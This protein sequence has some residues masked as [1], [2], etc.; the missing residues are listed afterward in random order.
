MPKQSYQK[1]L[2]SEV[3]VRFPAFQQGFNQRWF[4]SNCEAVYL[5][6]TA[7]GA[8]EALDDALAS[9]G[10]G[11]KIKSGG[12][13]Y[14]NFVFSSETKAILDVTAMTESGYDP[15]L[16]YF[17]SSGDTNW[18][19]FKV[20]FR[21]Y[22]KVL[23]AGSCYSVGLGGHISGGGDGILSRM[24][25]LTIDW[26]SGVEVVVKDEANQP[27]KVKYVSSE[28][29]GDDYD[30][31]WAHT[32]GGGGNF[33][34]ITKYYFKELPDSPKGAIISTLSFSWDDLTAIRIGLILDW[35]VT[36]AAQDYNWRTSC[37][38]QMMHKSAGYMKLLI[39][40]AYFTDDEKEQ[41]RLYHYQLE[42]ELESICPHV[43]ATSYSAGHAGVWSIPAGPR[44]K[45]TSM[46]D[47]VSEQTGDYTYYEAVQTMNSSG[48]NQR[49]KYKSAYMAKK[50]PDAQIQQIFKHLQ[51]IPD[52]LTA[53]AMTQSLLQVDTF[54]GQIN[55][56]PS[57][58]TAIAQRSYL[59]KLQYQ[60]YWLSQEDDP[61]HLEWIRTFYEQMYQPYGGTPNPD[62][63][64]DPEGL[65]EGCYYNYPDVDLNQYGGI[66]GA[67]WLYFLDNYKNN[68]RNLVKV[69]KRWDPNNYFHSLQ[70][71][72]VI[73]DPVPS[74]VKNLYGTIEGVEISEYVMNSGNNMEVKIITYGGTITSVKV[75]D[76]EGKIANIV[77][78][79]KNLDDYV[80][81]NNGPHFGS[82]IGRYANR[83]ANGVFELNGIFY[84]LDINDGVN[85]IHGG[86]NGFGTKVWTAKN[87]TTDAN[88]VS[89]EL[90]YLS[91][92]GDGWT[93]KAPNHAC[94]PFYRH[95]FPG[96]LD[97]TVTY[98][99]TNKNQL[100]IDY[101]A[102]TDEP[103]VLNLTNHTY[104]NL[105]GE[106]SG[107]ILDSIVTINSAQFTPVDSNQIPIGIVESVVETPFDFQKPKPAG[108]DVRAD[109][110]Q[111]IYCRGYDQNWVL[112]AMSG[113]P[114]HAVKLAATVSDPTSLR[115][116]KIFTN[117]PGLQFYTG[118][119]LDGTL[120]G[121]SNHE[122]RQSDGLALET[123]HYPNSP[124]QPNFPS[125][126]L[127][128]GETF[129]SRTIF[130]LGCGQ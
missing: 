89:L 53:E 20:L 12:H 98:T 76:H 14:E 101:K 117:Q 42:S 11:I 78:G 66:D 47:A 24:Y 95:G 80:S 99:L 102:T 123:Q 81:K 100:I 64:H 112:P 31:Y 13:C 71:I 108:Q 110:L 120:Y 72:P 1:I 44:A 106:G 40:S 33:G 37:K 104:W 7:A 55:T 116:L 6:F 54:G 27:A 128:P 103:T 35:Y 118:N 36:F 18:G 122:Y 127:N 107:T 74:I 97:T 28:S 57:D 94:K 16:G 92:A 77:L 96:N 21:N 29:E 60:T 15:D 121:T 22:G 43:P 125:T 70:S 105:A 63:L 124:N 50:F 3:D 109:V 83:I 119:S 9:Y 87:V 5:C 45:L 65:F 84:C 82:I 61:H 129:T 17:L 58:A 46:K 25:G 126:L 75:P 67:L 49:G 111:L 90:N 26:L 73:A 2:K 114:E 19:A 41:S 51:I 86:C 68:P 113:Q 88:S 130:D 23:P 8:A 32:G 48:P 79:F 10:N 59:V 62:P 30:L 34:V 85:S 38:F 56:V 91:P 93:G 52:G 115:V 69:K 4:A 39:H